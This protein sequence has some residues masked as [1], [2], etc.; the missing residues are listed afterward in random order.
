LNDAAGS[1]DAVRQDPPQGS[2]HH[3]RSAGEA[4][5]ASG[6]I[7]VSKL[8]LIL[9]VTLAVVAGAAVLS[10]SR[11]PTYRAEADVLVQPRLAPGIAVQAPAMATEKAVASSEVVL[12]TA[13]QA[14]DVPLSQ[15]VHG[16]SVTVPI[17]ANVLKIAYS[18]PHPG[19]AQRRAQ[20]VADAYVTYRSKSSAGSSAPQAAIITPASIPT[21][22][23]SPKHVID[24]GVALLVG[25]TLG[26]GLALFLDR[27]DRRLRSPLDFQRCVD[28]P[29]LGT[30]PRSPHRT[31]GLPNRPIAAAS[32]DS[33]EAAAYRE[34]RTRLLQIATRRKQKV[35]LVTSSTKEDAATV[36][37]NVAVTL[38]SASVGVVLLCADLR[39]SRTHELFGLDD[40][41]GLVDCV[42]GDA[43]LAEAL[44]HTAV[45][46]LRLLAAGATQDSGAALQ[47]PAF[48][49]LL[50]QLRESAEFIVIDAPPVLGRADAGLLAE[51]AAE[52]VLFVGDARRST[53]VEVLTAVREFDHVRPKLIGCVLCDVGRRRRPE[54]VLGLPRSDQ[55]A[56]PMA[57]AEVT[58]ARSDTLTVPTPGID[59]T[60]TQ[61]Q[62]LGSSGTYIDGGGEKP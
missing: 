23:A 51:S 36:A 59:L 54:T 40:K 2:A 3:D 57:P 46:N 11:T 60:R 39:S 17:D 47:R 19:E 52:M 38:A 9:L 32:P 61:S 12:A 56:E 13:A 58:P 6:R 27:S 5:R 53:R 26:I 1:A 48:T 18:G 31:R 50:S 24:I 4:G 22:P 33:P 49:H 43:Q 15:L 45:P 28:A 20:A 55:S 21:S 42:A 10:W 62:E 7:L 30:I 14:L 29:L 8:G 16:L 34:L 37:A 25:L 35:L 44:Q 41:I